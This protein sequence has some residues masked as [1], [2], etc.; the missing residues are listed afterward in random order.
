MGCGVSIGPIAPQPKT[1]VSDNEAATSCH[2]CGTKGHNARSPEC[3][4]RGKPAT[5]AKACGYC[6]R[7]DHV[8][9]DCP[10]V[11]ARRKGKKRTSTTRSGPTPKAVAA[12]NGNLVDH[13]R[14]LSADV[15]RGQTAERELAEVKKLLEARGRRR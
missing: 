14:S 9:A 10:R 3:P 15:E 12:V 6:K 11:E 2:R 5:S 7:T 13:I 8:Y 4:Q 1:S